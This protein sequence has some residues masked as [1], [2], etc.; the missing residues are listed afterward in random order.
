MGARLNVEIRYGTSEEDVLAN[1][2]YHWDAYSV[3][4]ADHAESI[5][6]KYNEM[7]EIEDK[8]TPEFAV[9]LLIREAE[10]FPEEERTRYTGEME[11]P[12]VASRN[13]GIISIFEKG[14]AETRLN[15]EMTLIVDILHESINF[16]QCTWFEKIPSNPEGEYVL[17]ESK[18]D[19]GRISFKEFSEFKKL[20]YPDEGYLVPKCHGLTRKGEPGYMWELVS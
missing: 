16:E 3:T 18:W 11:L 13:D 9:K 14:I 4:A 1:C 17:L 8:D 12:P 6:E 7:K 5:I 2:Y 15:A 19:L 10:G 20:W